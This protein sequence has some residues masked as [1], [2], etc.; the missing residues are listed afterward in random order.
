MRVKGTSL[1]TVWGTWH[2]V[3][4]LMTSEIRREGPMD[5]ELGNHTKGIKTTW[6][7]LRRGF[8]I[9]D[10]SDLPNGSLTSWVLSLHVKSPRGWDCH[11]WYPLDYQ[12]SHIVN[13]CQSIGRY[14]HTHTQTHTHIHTHTLAAKGLTLPQTIVTTGVQGRSGTWKAPTRTSQWVSKH[15]L[16]KPEPSLPAL[17]L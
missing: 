8:L 10:P 14:I 11:K 5:R 4:V 15:T 7:C 6:S 13:V 12:L 3:T 1:V 9:L 16:M 17:F 2:G